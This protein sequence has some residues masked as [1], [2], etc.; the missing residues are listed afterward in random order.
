L[1]LQV[2]SEPN[3]H[4][5]ESASSSN[6]W[7]AHAHDAVR[8]QEAKARDDEAARVAEFEK[9]LWE[10]R[11]ALEAAIASGDQVLICLEFRPS[12]FFASMIVAG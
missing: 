6:E 1:N 9:L 12:N 2:G 3:P 7:V 4:G 5:V 10:Q 8:G 11:T